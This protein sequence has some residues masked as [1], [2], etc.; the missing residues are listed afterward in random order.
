DS[1]TKLSGGDLRVFARSG[2]PAGESGTPVHPAIV[3]AAFSLDERGEVFPRPV[4]VEDKFSVVML[5]AKRPGTTRSVEDSAPAI[6]RLLNQERRRA[7]I[8]RLVEDLAA[9]VRPAKHPERLAPIEIAAP[10]QPA[11]LPPHPEH[12][13]AGEHGHSH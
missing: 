12:D 11:G 2:L 7:A 1:E 4:P 5:T 6:R 13:R 10:S 9:R 3:A 8:E